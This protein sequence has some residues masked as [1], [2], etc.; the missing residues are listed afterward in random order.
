MLKDPAEKAQKQIRQDTSVILQFIRRG[1]MKGYLVL[2]L[3]WSKRDI[4]KIQ[5]KLQKRGNVKC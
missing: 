5:E 3:H 1:R 2:D 4:P